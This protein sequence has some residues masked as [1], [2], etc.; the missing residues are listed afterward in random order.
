MTELAIRPDNAP[1]HQSRPL[2]EWAHEA[3]AA[4]DLASGLVDT[5]FC[6]D[7]FRGKPMHAAAAILAG[8]EVGLSPMAALN[9]YDVIQGRP[10]PKAITLRALVQ[11]HG[12]DIWMESSTAER[13]VMRGQR[14]GSNKVQEST[15][16]MKRARDMNLTNKPNWKSQPQAMLVARATSEVAR[17]VAADVILGIPYSAEELEDQ[18]P[19][20][21]VAM[22]RTPAEDAPKRTAKRA[23]PVVVPEPDLA[24]PEPPAE[25]GEAITAPQLRKLHAVMGENGLGDR[26]EGLRYLSRVVG[27]EVT[28]SK[29]LTKQE[30]SEVIDA[31]ENVPDEP[32][33]EDGAWPETAKPADA[34]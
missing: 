17:L 2:V 15:W 21:V 30:A 13:C 19:T 23:A 7:A 5:P 9:A 4:H 12:H 27:R 24:E 1:V 10:A 18:Q 31:L 14:R 34:S 3:R 26:E 6:P 16:D 28:T 22:S 20:P 33:V 32:P 29:A 25:T 8:S 11:S